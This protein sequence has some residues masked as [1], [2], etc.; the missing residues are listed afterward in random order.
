MGLKCFIPG[1]DVTGE[2]IC[3]QRQREI[4]DQALVGTR[5]KGNLNLTAPRGGIDDRIGILYVKVT[6]QGNF[7]GGKHKGISRFW[8]ADER[9]FQ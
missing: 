6:A 8:N 5:G 2:G 7:R 3:T 4:E 9:V 1:L